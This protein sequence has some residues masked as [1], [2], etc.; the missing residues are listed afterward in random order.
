[1]KK[2]NLLFWAALLIGISAKPQAA[3]IEPENPDV[4]KPVRLYCDISKTTAASADNMKNNPNGPFY[5]WT[6]KP[7]EHPSGHPLANG[8]GDKTWKNSNDALVMVKDDTK[9]ANVWYYEMIPT[10]FYGVAA[11]E[12]YSKG[13]AF[14]VKPKDGGGWG[15][16]DIKTEDFNITVEP[17]KL[18]RGTLY[19]VP[20]TVLQHKL[21][22]LIYDNPLELKETM[23]NLN[24]GDVFMHI[25]VTITDTVSGLT[26]KLEPATFSRV[27]NLPQLQMKK[28]TDGRF[29]ITMIPHRFFNI[30]DTAIL[31]EIEV[32]VRKR[33]WASF[34][35]QTSEKGRI[36]AGCN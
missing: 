24:E 33:N 25:V 4:T 12:I 36:K 9:G 14:L 29:K 5:I 7:V 34:A 19:A 32:T 26:S 21:T 1:M 27:T 15:D 18:N 23:K 13:I 11:T 6:W 10:E 30:P 22:S 31:N 28:M 3:W 20:Q 8:L 35:D 16:P 2:Y 17:P